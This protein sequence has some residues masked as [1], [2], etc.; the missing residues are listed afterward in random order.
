MPVAGACCAVGAASLAAVPPFA[1]F[2]SVLM[3]V[4][5]AVMT[6]HW[7]V[8]AAVVL[9]GLG[10]AVA[11]ARMQKYALF[12]PMSARVLRLSGGPGAG[13]SLALLGLAVAWVMPGLVA[14]AVEALQRGALG[15]H[16]FG[17][18]G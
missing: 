1:G 8:A 6:G 16:G 12:G 2:W 14:P 11:L 9:A 18:P 7:L 17:G 4:A 15:T 13:A 3:I 5:G 10:T